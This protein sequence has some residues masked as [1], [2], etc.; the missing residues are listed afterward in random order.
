MIKYLKKNAQLFLKGMA[1][2]TANII[3]GVS[4]GTIAFLLGIYDEMIEAIAGIKKHFLK[5]LSFLLPV[6]LGALLAILALVFPISWAFDHYPLPLVTLFAGL[7]IGGLPS[8]SKTINHQGSPIRIAVLVIG[9]TI[10]LLLGVLSVLTSFDASSVLAT[11][12]V[13]N[14]LIIIFVG[15]IGSS[16]M[17]IPGISGSMLLLVIGFYAPL[18]ELIS[19]MMTALT[20]GTLFA[21]WTPIL[22]MVLF[23]IG[24][25]VGFFL[26]SL[27]MQ[28]LLDKYKT[29]TYF[30]IIGFILGSLIALYYNYE[31]VGMYASLPW[32][33]IPIAISFLA[34][35]I[36]S[37]LAVARYGEKPQIKPEYK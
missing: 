28:F 22:V 4:G 31:V 16:A 25:V 20:N 11:L 1:I 30:G 8:L 23:V 15:I 19:N 5:S 34:L 3:P 18:T 6:L 27:L 32:W 7:I 13:G 29:A 17:V 9:F 14:A 35:G 36:I 21:N 10:A 37:S 26:I 12:S 33:H 24:I 2:G